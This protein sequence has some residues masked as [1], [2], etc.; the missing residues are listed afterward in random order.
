MTLPD[1]QHQRA[2]TLLELLIVI[3]LMGVMAMLLVGVFK[4]AGSREG[5]PKITQ[6]RE[7]VLKGV[8]GSRELFCIDNCTRCFY[9]E[10]GEVTEA[11]FALPPLSAYIVDAE[12][13]PHR[14]E[15]GRYQDHPV[16]LRFRSAEDGHTSRLIIGSEG[17][18][19]YIPSYFGEVERYASLEDA[20]ARW[21]RDR[22]LLHNRWDY[23]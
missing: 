17:A 13:Q 3:L 16:C 19:Y 11:G 2:F 22:D 6:L 15:Y 1:R 5:P 8:K 7:K 10:G 20:V 21:T 14:L 12:G 18:F 23:Y 4:R 9:L